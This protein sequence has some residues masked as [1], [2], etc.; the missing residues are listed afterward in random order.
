M[1]VSSEQTSLNITNLLPGTLYTLQV[2]TV[3]NTGQSSFPSVPVVAM[4]PC[5]LLKCAQC[6][7]SPIQLLQSLQMLY[8]D[9]LLLEGVGNSWIS[10]SWN[11]SSNKIEVTEQIILV[12]GRGTKKNITVDVA[13]TQVNVTDL[14]SGTEYE[15]RVIVV[16][17]DGKQANQVLLL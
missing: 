1:I 5:M 16:A 10:F 6:M 13:Q 17:S 7:C 15:L 2:V 8:T 4:F 3:D 9:G 12:S 14:Q 11:Q